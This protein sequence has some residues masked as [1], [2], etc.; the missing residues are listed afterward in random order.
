MFKKWLTAVGI[1]SAKVDTRLTTDELIPGGLIAGEIHLSGGDADQSVS[2]LELALMTKVEVEGDDVKFMANHC[3]QSWRIPENFIIEAHTEKAIPFSY[4]LSAE[5]P[6]TVSGAKQQQTTLWLQ[7]GVDIDLALDPKDQD[8]LR[9]Y[10]S[11]PMQAVLD[12]MSELGFVLMQADVE[13]GYINTPTARTTSGC[14]Q[15]FEFK[16]R[17]MGFSISEV[18]I[19]FVPDGGLLHVLLEVDRRL[20][21]DQYQCMTIS[22]NQ[23][24]AEQIKAELATL[25]RL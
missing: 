6:V 5:L 3:L 11:S 7:T 1:G 2:G 12:A 24:S 25:M 19:S 13:K 4:Q 10:P 23:W 20:A 9:V 22:L 16:P 15:E 17:R 21:G 18:E 14:Y 8:F